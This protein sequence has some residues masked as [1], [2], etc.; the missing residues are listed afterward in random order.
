MT[1]SL[2]VLLTSARSYFLARRYDEAIKPLNQFLSSQPAH[3]GALHLRGACLFRTGQHAQALAD[4]ARAAKTNPHDV[5][6][7]YMLARAHWTL[8]QQT[9]AVEHA[10][11][12]A[13][14]GPRFGPAHELL[15][16]ID[17]PG[18][19]YTKVLAYVHE[20][21]R[22]STYVEIGI[23]KGDSLV[24]VRPETNALGIDPD[25]DLSTPP[26]PNW[27]IYAMTSDDFFANHDV[28]EELGGRAV[29]LAF[30]DGMHH[31]DFALRDFMNLEPHCTRGATVLVHDAYP[32]DEKTARRER[33]TEFWSGDIWRLILALKRHRPDLDVHVI[34]TAPTG[35]GVIRNLD[36]GSNVIRENYDRI[37]SEFLD[38]EFGVLEGRKAELL[39][40]FPNDPDRIR[41]L[42]GCA[43][44]N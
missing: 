38:L 39:N 35:L 32:L 43:N 42:L 11:V 5:N 18:P 3:F 40:L 44:A 30:I 12:A 7:Q 27:R 2:D 16:R 22:P 17:M 6:N 13:E 15:A 28:R 36:P 9:E 41:T 25:P 33:V 23:F 4:F 19:Y 20:Q 34:A 24:M 8:G 21:L 26:A 10:R 31:F 14:A 1:E 37:V 29:E